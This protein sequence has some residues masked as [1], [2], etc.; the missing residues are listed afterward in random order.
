MQ[1]TKGMLTEEE[2]GWHET[3]TSKSILV[4]KNVSN[5]ILL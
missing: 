1:K 5:R 2:G 4:I 3:S